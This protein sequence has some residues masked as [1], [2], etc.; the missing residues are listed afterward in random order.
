MSTV[1]LSEAQLALLRFIT[2]KASEDQHHRD[3]WCRMLTGPD[4]PWDWDDARTLVDAGLV[5]RRETYMD[6][7]LK[8]TD[9]GW[10]VLAASTEGG[11]EHA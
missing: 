1:Q 3:G 8:P 9:R 6:V 7:L 4:H 5:Q 2:R 10:A 11:D